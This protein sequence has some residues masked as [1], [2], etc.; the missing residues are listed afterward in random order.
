MKKTTVKIMGGL[1]NQLH[2]YA[3]G[4][5]ISYT[6]KSQLVVDNQSG[7]WND[8]YNR[9]FMLNHFPNYNAE[10]IDLR[11]SNIVQFLFKLKK[12]IFYNISNCLSLRFKFHIKENCNPYHFQ[13]ELLA[14]R[15]FFNSYF[16]GYWASYKYYDLI[17]EDLRKEFLPPIPTQDEVLKIAQK[18][19]KSES[20]AIHIRSYKEESGVKRVNLKKYYEKSILEIKRNCSN[21]NFYIFS[22][23]HNFAKNLLVDLIDEHF[24]F[25][26][27][28]AAKG[29]IQ[30][31]N[32]FYLIYICSNAII[33]DST[34]SW[35]AS[36][37]SDNSKKHIIAPRGLSPW[38]DDWL[39]DNWIAL[40]AV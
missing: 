29:N 35:W 33:G 1:G 7:Y 12:K 27:L 23:D 36:W 28:K 5:A 22:D 39:P 26:N 14:R 9:E 4:R 2:C 20:C 10:H 13:E 34:F 40:D 17:K 21:T 18:I 38:G 25:V 24:N 16:E 32:D 15:P 6:N 31:F 11:D 3:F 19:K 30:S 37:L 8:Q